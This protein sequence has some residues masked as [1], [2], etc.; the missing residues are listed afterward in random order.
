ME[1]VEMSCS[2]MRVPSE[3][4]VDPAAAWSD[5]T[6]QQRRQLHRLLL[7][8]I[9]I[10]NVGYRNGPRVDPERLVVTW[11]PARQLTASPALSASA[12]HFR[13]QVWGRLSNS[14]VKDHEF[15]DQMVPG[16]LAHRA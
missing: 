15:P 2:R 7:A 9:A 14:V 8:G 16:A 1:P 12:A 11:G 4:L 3:A 6:M 13:H 10:K 5:W